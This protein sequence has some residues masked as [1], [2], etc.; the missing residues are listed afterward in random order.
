MSAKTLFR[1]EEHLYS[2][3]HLVLPSTLDTALKYVASRNAGLS[4]PYDKLDDS[5][6]EDE[7]QGIVG[8]FGV[9]NVHGALTYR[10][11]VGMCGETKGVS[12]QG[13]IT[14]VSSMI[15]AGVSSI[16]MDMDTPGGQAYAA[17]DTANEIR[18]LCTDAGVKLY[19]YVDG[20]CASAGYVLACVADEVISHPDAMSG[21]IGCVVALQNANK[22]LNN[23]GI[24]IT[25][26]TSA[27]AKVPFDADGEFKADFIERVQAQ[28][29]A[30]G[31]EFAQHVE[32]HT[33][34]PKETILSLEANMFNARDAQEIGLVNKI[35]TKRQ[36]VAY[37][38]EN[39]K[40]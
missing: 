9:I 20:S 30:L 40:E 37:V 32:N 31:L 18:Q 6:D 35:M 12:Y 7:S 17:F 13:L 39:S 14:T 26:I 38:T 36:F 34:L 2:T 8:N 10:P 23:M 22:A 29:N 25:Y 1:F 4:D 11:V 16:I 5:E 24:K 33:G 28:V 27:S 15:N 21:S 3:P 19:A